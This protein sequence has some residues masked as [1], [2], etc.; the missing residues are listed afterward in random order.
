VAGIVLVAAGTQVIPAVPLSAVVVPTVAAALP[1]VP[2]DVRIEANRERVAAAV[3]QATPE[4]AAVFRQILDEGRQLLHFDPEANRGRG[5]WA[6][7]VGSITERTRAVG[8]LVAGGAAFIT[9]DNF[10]RYYERAAGLVEEA[11]GALA[12]VVWAAGTFPQ[13]WI[14][15]A[16][17]HY[18]APLGRALALFSHELRVEITRRAGP[19]APA[20]VVVVGH[21][22][23]G[24]VVGTAERYGMD[25]D[26]VLHI[27]SVGLGEVRDPYDYPAPQRPRYSMTAPGDLIGYVQ[28]ALTPPGVGHGPDPDDFRCV[29]TLPTGRLPDDPAARDELG[30][31]LG[32]RAGV[33]IHGIPSHSDVFIH[34]SDA[35]W[36]IFRVLVGHAPPPGSCP[37]PPDPEPAKLRVL[38]LAVPQATTHSQCRT[39]GGW[40]AGGRKRRRPG[41]ASGAGGA[42]SAGGGGSAG[43][44]PDA[45]TSPS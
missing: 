2:F 29:R 45:P 24:A 18:D 43:G 42:G 26:A 27:A 40:R 36:Q 19:D 17:S 7:L 41:G 23:G 9:G 33:R 6:E 16:L 12:M 5:S 28:G 44:A 8:V 4:T 11:G 35:W 21:S 14:Q 15:G 25:A 10:T 34:H 32:D 13:G 22:Y 38:P 20:R 3:A 1:T 30:E 37:P 39:G 31:P